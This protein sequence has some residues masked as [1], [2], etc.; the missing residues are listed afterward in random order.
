MRDWGGRDFASNT[1]F[2]RDLYA[3]IPPIADVELVGKDRDPIWISELAWPFAAA[4]EAF[5]PREA[6]LRVKHYDAVVERVGN[7]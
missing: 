5:A 3:A 1:F 7:V 4:P 6:R 2:D